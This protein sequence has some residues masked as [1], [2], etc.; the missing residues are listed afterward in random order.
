MITMLKTVA[1]NPRDVPM[2]VEEILR[3]E[4]R[5]AKVYFAIENFLKVRGTIATT[6]GNKNVF[7]HLFQTSDSSTIP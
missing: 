6:R 3:L 7:H 2:A 4:K 1:A 5:I